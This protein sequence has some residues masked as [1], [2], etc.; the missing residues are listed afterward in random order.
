MGD[1]EYEEFTDT[2][3]E[4]GEEDEEDR[5]QRWNAMLARD[6]AAMAQFRAQVGDIGNQ[7]A[8]LLDVDW[9]EVLGGA[10]INQDIEAVPQALQEHVLQAE[11][12]SKSEEFR[13]FVV[14]H[15]DGI[16]ALIAKKYTSFVEIKVI[17]DQSPEK[18]A[19]VS[20][21]EVVQILEDRSVYFSDL[22]KVYDKSSAELERL[23]GTEF[24]FLTDDEFF[25]HMQEIILSSLVE[26][27]GG[28][29]T[30]MEISRRSGNN[31]SRS[32]SP[33]IL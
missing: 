16:S 6:A 31:S 7:I 1:R 24:A 14:E 13:S 9:A 12:E 15:L 30:E 27:P 33:G 3:T 26:Q 4:S 20:A 8:F 25:A 29:F 19:A 28:R 10:A 2:D 17:Y 23:V 18:L 11:W 5:A 22:C 32:S 21:L